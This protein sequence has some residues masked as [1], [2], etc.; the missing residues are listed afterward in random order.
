MVTNPLDHR[1]S[2]GVTDAEAFTD[3]APYKGL[4]AGCAVQDDVA[5]DDVLFCNEADVRWRA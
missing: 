4:T 5:R 1:V 3:P 2:A